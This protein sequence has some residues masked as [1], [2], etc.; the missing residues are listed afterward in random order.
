[1]V[2]EAGEDA[3]RIEVGETHEVDRAIET[4]ERNRV[5]VTNDTVIFY[6]LITQ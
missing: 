5:E 2:E 1:M 6:G 4:G 3:G